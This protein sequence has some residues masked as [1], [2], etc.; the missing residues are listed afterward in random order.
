[1]QLGPYGPVTMDCVAVILCDYLTPGD[2]SRL[3]LVSVP[4]RQALTL[5]HT[6]W[7]NILRSK[8]K[9]TYDEFVSKMS[10]KTKCRE[11]CDTSTRRMEINVCGS[12]VK[13]TGSYSEM[14]CRAYIR[15]AYQKV[16]GFRCKVR[17]LNEFLHAKC[18]RRTRMKK[19]LYW[20]S[21]VVTFFN[22]RQMR[23]HVLEK[24]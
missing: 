10:K 6:I 23:S 1:M 20:K 13:D 16:V 18:V 8:R 22:E 9:C 24:K 3:S 21:D 11:C 5:D 2:V 15:N 4:V 17:V 19:L 14:V 12:C 7:T